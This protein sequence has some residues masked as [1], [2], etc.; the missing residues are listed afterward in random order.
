VK[1]RFADAGDASSSTGV[2]ARTQVGAEDGIP[3]SETVAW[4]PGVETGVT[5]YS[6]VNATLTFVPPVV[7]TGLEGG[8]GTNRVPAVPFR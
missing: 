7:H 1:V 8:V 5:K 2:P 6:S 4:P 3:A